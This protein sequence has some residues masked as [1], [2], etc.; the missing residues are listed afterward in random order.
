MNNF[1]VKTPLKLEDGKRLI[2][3]TSLKPNAVFIAFKR[4][5]LSRF[6]HMGISKVLKFFKTKINI[7]TNSNQNKSLVE[8][9]NR[10]RL[11]IRIRNSNYHLSDLE[12]Y[13]KM[14][15]FFMALKN[16]KSNYLQKIVFGMNRTYPEFESISHLESTVA[17]NEIFSFPLRIDEITE[18]INTL[19]IADPRELEVYNVASYCSMKSI[20]SIC[21]N[22]KSC[23]FSIKSFFF[24]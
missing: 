24:L 12:N 16:L 13:S 5:I 20:M 18:F 7:K 9:V 19:K 10:K 8:E 6:L 11:E 1:P 3:F 2:E 14:N 21:S 4:R 15:D 17:D 22:K 23:F